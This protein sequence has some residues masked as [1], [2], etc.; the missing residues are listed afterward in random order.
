MPH[1]C[2]T[3]SK[4]AEELDLSWLDVVA[5]DLLRPPDSPIRG[6]WRQDAAL[7]LDRELV[8][9]AGME[10]R[11]RRVQAELARRL[12]DTRAWR[13]LGFVRLSDYARE[14]LGLSP[15]SLEED[16]R[17]LRALD[18]L[19]RLGA[20]MDAGAIGWTQLRLLARVATPHNEEQLL[21]RSLGVS[22]RELEELVREFARDAASNSNAQAAESPPDIH[23]ASHED[24]FPSVLG[25]AGH[26]SGTSGTSGASGASA[27]V[28]DPSGAA[29]S[30]GA[31]AAANSADA[32]DTDLADTK[33]AEHD[34]DDPEIRWGLLVS[35]RGRR[36][37]RTARELASRTAG[38]PL[39]PAEVLEKIAA[40][41]V[42][43][44]PPE[45]VG[46]DAKWSPPPELQE[47]RLRDLQRIDE[48]RGQRLVQA[49]LAETGV[50][51]GFPWLE[52]ASRDAGPARCLDA[53]LEELESADAF[54][55][56][57]RLH[58][59]R[60]AMQRID[61]QM[62]ALLRIGADRRLFRELGF[63][64]VKLYV[65]A[66]LGCCAR[67]VW[68]LIAIERE[69]WRSC[70]QLRDA[71]R[72]GR[73]SHL[74]ACTLLPVMSEQH[75]EAWLRRASEVTLRRLIDEVAWA[76][77]RPDREESGS[78]YARPAPPPPGA[79]IRI[80]VAAAVTE[81]EVQMRAHGDPCDSGIG[82]GG[83][84][85]LDLHVPL[86]IAVLAET[87]LYQLRTGS[88]PRWRVFERMVAL[89]IL[90]W[91]AVPRHRDPVFD[92]DGWRCS[93]PG[94]SSRRNLHDHHVVFR[95]QGGDNARDNRTTVCAA[96][97]LHGLHAGIIK[98]RGRAPS[99]IEWD[100]G[101]RP[102][103]PP[104]MRTIGD[105]VMARAA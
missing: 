103:R 16:A 38:S 67:K 47:R 68:S 93:V 94:C 33:A 92:R 85:R 12:I 54:A 23:G 3:S 74:A 49:F 25:T 39:S 20:A 86:S 40:E 42:S 14:R 97:H 18:S 89:A 65:E 75:G 55:L 72:D 56:D 27:A 71:W 64:T 100:V 52:P 26:S 21:R 57:H 46:A 13:P 34:N 29:P 99:D 22:T 76:L 70:P 82:P 11:C 63:A 62:G 87:A 60:L 51:E 50:A 105:R 73:L 17:V 6:S 43:G 66:R 101:C 53:L 59:A 58:Q 95:S 61:A 80:D 96:H 28:S 83:A 10:A 41:A 69:T 81:A 24:D 102:D 31:P 4:H 90:E 77:D 79:D 9:L 44:A 15:R 104:F 91:S 19:P 48:A 98:A 1:A 45:F 84:V 2:S 32:A 78:P 88:E 36:M 5:P 35:R 30:P 8:V 37:W 7:V